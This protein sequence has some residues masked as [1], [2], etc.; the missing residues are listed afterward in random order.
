MPKRMSAAVLA[1]VLLASC[2][3]GAPNRR[4]AEYLDESTSATIT[5]AE[6][7]IVLYS[8]DPAR[9]ANARDYL[10]LAPLVVNQ[11]GRRTCWLWLGAWSTIDRGAAGGDAQRAVIA[12]VT[13]IVDGEPMELAMAERNGQIPGIGQ[14]P[15]ATPVATATDIILPLTGSQ[16][17]RL[18]HAGGILVY[19]RMADGE[20]LQ[21][22]PWLRN[23][24]PTA[25]ADLAAAASPAP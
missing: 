9:A 13:L 14:L 16:L 1:A 15:Y 3:S 4:A 21:W 22:R 24:A 23:G 20:T 5:R 7:P 10:Y 12:D 6:S 2:G 18:S 8:E 11:S 17:E 19:T 25:F